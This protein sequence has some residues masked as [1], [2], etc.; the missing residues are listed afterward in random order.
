MVGWRAAAFP[1]FGSYPNQNFKRAWPVPRSMRP[2]RLARNI[3]IALFACRSATT[4]T[5][6]QYHRVPGRDAVELGVVRQPLLGELGLVPVHI[7]GNKLDRRARSERA[8]Q[9]RPPAQPWGAP[10]RGRTPGP[11]RRRCGDGSQSGPG[12]GPVAIRVELLRVQPPVAPTASF[13]PRRR[14]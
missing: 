13:A 14:S 8:P 9:P 3:E 11:S 1:P 2:I 5:M 7:G 4:A 6:Y 12:S 10:R